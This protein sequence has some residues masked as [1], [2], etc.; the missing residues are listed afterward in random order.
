MSIIDLACVIVADVR[1]QISWFHIK[2][3]LSV[4]L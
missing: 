1:D 3:L 4:N 2:H